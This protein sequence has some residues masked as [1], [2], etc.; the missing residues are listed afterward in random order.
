MFK[1]KS[2][3]NGFSVD[4]LDKAKVFYTKI[5]GL[6]VEDA[7]GGASILLPGGHK[8]WMYT[9]EDHQPATYTMLNF[10]VDDID[11]AVDEITNRGVS[12]EHYEGSP[13]DEKGIMRGKEHHMGPNIAWFKDSAGNI[14]SVLEATE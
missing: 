14:L 9:R 1:P 8:A 2:V 5:L 4:D 3:F 11:E 7:T 12:F 10:V 13:Q 6:K